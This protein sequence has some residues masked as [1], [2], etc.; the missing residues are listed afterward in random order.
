MG[1]LYEKITVT[2]SSRGTYYL[3]PFWF[4]RGFESSIRLHWWLN[5]RSRLILK[6]KEA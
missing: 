2:N 4:A 3:I 6:E 1:C 5:G